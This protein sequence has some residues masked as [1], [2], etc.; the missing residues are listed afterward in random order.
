MA[1]GLIPGLVMFVEKNTFLG[2]VVYLS[3][4]SSNSRK[5][6][7]PK[8]KAGTLCRCDQAEAKR[9]GHCT[10][11]CNAKIILRRLVM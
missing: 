6:K 4:P 11:Y 7:N 10:R 2:R 9:L 3:C 1:L 8:P 5:I